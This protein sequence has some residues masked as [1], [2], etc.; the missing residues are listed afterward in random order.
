LRPGN[1]DS[2]D[3][4]RTV[5]EPVIA[6]YG[7]RAI[8]MYFHADAAFARP[9]LYELPEAEE[10]AYAIR[11]PANRVLMARI[12]HLLTRAEPAATRRRPRSGA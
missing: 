8:D 7:E 4:R 2:A 10:I 6:R 11:R 3:D 12:G 9:E 1:V 5:L